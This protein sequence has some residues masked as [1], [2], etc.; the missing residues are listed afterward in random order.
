L[1]IRH[2]KYGLL[3]TLEGETTVPAA[4]IMLA[5]DAG[6]EIKALTSVELPILGGFKQPDTFIMNHLAVLA[7]K[8]SDYKKSEE[9]GAPVMEKLVKEFTNSFYGKFSQAIN[10]RKVF[11]PATGEMVTLGESTITEPCTAALT[12]SLARAALSATL[13]AVEKFNKRRRFLSKQ[14][15]VISATTDGLLIG[16]PVPKNFTVIDDYYKK[17]PLELKGEVSINYPKF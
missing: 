14:I 6:A 16:V 9:A 3:Y 5:M 15:T 2:E 10:P 1:P 7:N 17:S 11:S 12:T 4:E 13:L 8:R